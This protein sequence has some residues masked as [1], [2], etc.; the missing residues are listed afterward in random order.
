[1]LNDDF[2][3]TTGFYD[4]VTGERLPVKLADGAMADV[5]WVTLKEMPDE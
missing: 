1:M 5:G 2:G 4:P 3:V